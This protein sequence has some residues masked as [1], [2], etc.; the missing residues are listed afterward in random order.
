M[1]IF[2]ALFLAVSQ[3]FSIILISL[4]A[5][6]GAINSHTVFV[7]PTIAE[8][9]VV[10]TYTK[11]TAKSTDSGYADFPAKKSAEVAGPLLRTTLG[12]PP[13]SVILPT[14]QIPVRPPKDPNQLNADARAALVN[15]LCLT[16]AGGY[17]HPLSGSGVF[18]DTRG[19]ILT[20]AHVGQFFLLR[21]YPTKDNIVCAIRTGSPAQ[22]TYYA[23]L[24]Y[25]PP[26]WISANASQI[27]AQQETGTGENDFAFLLVTGST[28]ATPLPSPP[29]GGFPALPV[30]LQDPAVGDGTLLAAYPAGF[31]DG[32]SIQMNLFA[33]STFT[34]IEEIF[35]FNNEGRIDL[36][37]LGGTIV[38]QAG[39]SGGAV[40]RAQDGYLEG[41]IATATASSTTAGRDLRAITTGHIDR[42]LRADGLGGIEGILSGNLNETAD[43]FN[44]DIAPLLTQKLLD[45]LKK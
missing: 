4:G 40:V 21:D 7:A 6:F 8:P 24:L 26:V 43:V 15:I 33:A 23:R 36:M 11:P 45:V 20:N 27:T 1:Q 39:S 25:L 44:R 22:N 3:T 29:A 35:T 9:Q 17:F 12:K 13:P 42:S 16:G 19:V 18:V 14:V 28:G 30:S 10:A 41:I 32:S 34:T 2:H 5:F 38:S 31:L 37:S